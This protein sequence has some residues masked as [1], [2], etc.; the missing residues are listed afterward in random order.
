[1]AIFQKLKKSRK[2]LQ[3]MS[4]ESRE[5]VLSVP[6][7]LQYL[8]A[9]TANVLLPETTSVILIIEK[10]L[11]IICIVLEIFKHK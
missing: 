3:E 10:E 9:R 8:K 2:K 11:Y 6:K 4:K 1:M 5:N 7:H